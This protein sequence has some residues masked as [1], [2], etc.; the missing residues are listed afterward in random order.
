MTVHV[1]RISKLAFEED[2]RWWITLH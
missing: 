1:H 2:K